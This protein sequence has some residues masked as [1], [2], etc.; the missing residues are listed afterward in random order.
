VPKV[1]W[2]YQAS[3]RHSICGGAKVAQHTFTEVE[4]DITCLSCINSIARDK[5]R[6]QRLDQ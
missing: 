4:D 5:E 2:R 6:K 1:H 3:S